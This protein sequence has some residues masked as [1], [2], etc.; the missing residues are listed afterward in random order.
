MWQMSKIIDTIAGCELFCGARGVPVLQKPSEVKGDPA[1]ATLHAGKMVPGCA[2][3]CSVDEMLVVTI[4]SVSIDV[5]SCIA[6]NVDVDKLVFAKRLGDGRLFMFIISGA[7]ENVPQQVTL[8]A[9]SDVPGQLEHLMVSVLP[10]AAEFRV[11]EL[12]LD[13]AVL[14]SNVVAPG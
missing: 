3:C 9:G 4:S 2:K 1:Q 12:T 11:D 14:N 5:S 10:T 7:A 6:L 13:R 8:D